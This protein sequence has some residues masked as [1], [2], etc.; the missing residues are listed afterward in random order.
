MTLNLEK[1]PDKK[2]VNDPMEEARTKESQKNIG[3]AE[4]RTN[5]AGQ[6]AITANCD[7]A[8]AIQAERSCQ[9]TKLCSSKTM[10]KNSLNRERWDHNVVV[11]QTNPKLRMPILLS[12]SNKSRQPLNCGK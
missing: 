5:A 2:A 7:S 10:H 12:K 9:N 3:E 8:K 4:K 6:S 11:S 1:W